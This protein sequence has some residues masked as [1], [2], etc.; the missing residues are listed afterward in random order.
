MGGVDSYCRDLGYSGP[1]E[2]VG[3]L[4]DSGQ[5]DHLHRYWTITRA[6]GLRAL[7]YFLQ[8]GERDPGLSWVEQ[9]QSLQEPAEPGATD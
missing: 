2:M 5:L 9:P 3:F 1:D 6:E 4:L 7:G 8:H